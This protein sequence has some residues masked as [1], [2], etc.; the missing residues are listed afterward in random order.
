MKPKKEDLYDQ[1]DSATER[2]RRS[3]TMFAQEG[4]KVDEVAQELTVAQQAVGVNVDVAGFMRGA[5]QANKAI[6]RGDDPIQVD[7][8]EVPRAL[9]DTLGLEKEK[10][11]GTFTMPIRDKEIYLTRTHPLVEN[12]A[13]HVMD[14]ALDGSTEGIAKRCGAIRT[15]MVPTRTSLLLLRLRYHLITTRGGVEQ[16]LLAEEVYPIAF[17]GTPGE[18]EWLD[19]ETAESLVHA[20]PDAN[21]HPQ[22]ATHFVRQVIDGFGALETHLE[23]VAIER[24]EALLQSHRRVRDAAHHR[25]RYR[26]EP[27]LPIDVLGIYIYLPVI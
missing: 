18:A 4:I 11:V 9:K 15:Q 5:L 17:R 6:V 19:M 27:K 24:A 12:L 25:G 10:F 2:E 22:Q 20:S 8:G 26:V 1:W 14:T 21:I 23:S 16:A 13:A 7:L 3:R